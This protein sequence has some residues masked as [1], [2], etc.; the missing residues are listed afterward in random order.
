MNDELSNEE[1]ALLGL[2]GLCEYSSKVVLLIAYP[3]YG[4]LWVLKWLC[5]RTILLPI[6][7]FGKWFVAKKDKEGWPSVRIKTESEDK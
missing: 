3:I 5:F 4:F 2:L 1:Y 7:R 6:V